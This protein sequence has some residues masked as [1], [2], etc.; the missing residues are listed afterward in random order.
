MNTNR[1]L[2]GTL[3]GFIGY[4]AAGGLLYTQVFHN[5]LATHN[6]GFASVQ[7][8]PN[9]VALVIGNLVAA[10]LLSYVFEK[11]ASIRN[12]LTGALAGATIGLLVA[13][14]YDSMIHGTTTLMT[15]TGVMIDVLAYT[16]VSAV[17]GA[18][19]AFGLSY[20]RV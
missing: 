12:M 9:M 11:W 10:F 19:V 6:P 13:L 5:M 15:W 7:M 4:F 14:S 16:L 2:L 20:K 18:L 3:T 8:E 1:L 17:G